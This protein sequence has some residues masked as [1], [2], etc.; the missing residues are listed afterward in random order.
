[1]TSLRSYLVRARQLPPHVAAQ[2]AA[3]LIVRTLRARLHAARDHVRPT[4]AAQP[5]A[6]R[7]RWRLRDIGTNLSFGSPEALAE[8]TTCYLQ[9]RFDILGSGWTEIRHGLEC[10]GFAGHRYP[11]G[12]S[13][14]ADPDGRWLASRINGSNLAASQRIWRMIRPPYVPIDWQLDI[15]SGYRWSE[16]KHY[17]SIRYG[18]HPGVDVKV[19]WELARLQ[20]LPQL[21]I[22][23]RVALAGVSGFASADQYRDEI[24]NQILDFI[25]TNPPRFGV[26]WTCAMDVAIRIVNV[27]TALDLL[28]AAGARLEAGMIAVFER[29]VWDHAVHIIGNLEWSPGVRSNHY[30]SNIA[31]LIFAAAYLP[32]TADTD[33]WLA[34]AVR[35][36]LV[37]AQAQFLADGG[38]FEASTGY[39][40][41]SAELVLFPVALVLGLEADEVDAISRPHRRL[42]VRP[43][44]AGRPLA[45]EAVA[46]RRTPIPPWLMAA[47]GKAAAL[48]RDAGKPNGQVVQWGDTDSGRLLKLQPAWRRLGTAAEPGAWVEDPLDHRA[49]IAGAARLTGDDDLAACAGGCWNDA[50]VLAALAGHGPAVAMRSSPPESMVADAFDFDAFIASAR[51]LPASQQRYLEF[52]LTSG[53]LDEVERAAYPEFGHYVFRAPRFYLA[54]RCPRTVPR[55]ASHAHDDTL[56]IELEIDGVPIFEDPGTYVYTPLP[57]E[58]NRYRTAAAHSVPRP[59]G[60]R[61]LDLSRGLFDAGNLLPGR[62]LYFGPRGFAGEVIG[63]DW[64][65]ARVVELKQ[66]SLRLIDASWSA[67]L[68]DLAP[69]ASLPPVCWGY[70][71][72][73][74]RS[75][76]SF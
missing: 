60:H 29:C 39:H 24:C 36:L 8:T 49:L 53:S 16:R 6:G 59:A 5:S 67:P 27:L 45:C 65:V 66:D 32:R 38:N 13:A 11:P 63:P 14:N 61:G 73:T 51:A 23:Y 70:G 37:E 3:A 57:D 44:Q 30:L 18:T 43:P 52:R 68:E 7:L 62:C 74:T 12:T 2:R 72:R 22:A 26:N 69:N 75:P 40:R 17:R 4:Y 41:L 76:R 28:H 33:T 55:S 19:P 47:L 58:R 56:A 1:V 50:E 10:P 35:E 20:H 15:K 48:T 9:H 46:G 64:T 21:A 34:F 31:G 71:R 42:D 54:V 25:A